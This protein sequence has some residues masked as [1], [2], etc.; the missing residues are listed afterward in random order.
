MR[1]RSW[2]SKRNLVFIR[3]GKFEVPARYTAADLEAMN[4]DELDK[5][6]AA[7][8]GGTHKALCESI[9]SESLHEVLVKHAQADRFSKFLRG[10]ADVHERFNRG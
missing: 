8:P 7:I 5:V 1:L 10:P 6:M 3:G 9:L 2:M 4:L